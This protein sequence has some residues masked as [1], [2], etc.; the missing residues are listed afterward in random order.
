MAQT[1][2]ELEPPDLAGWLWVAVGLLAAV[3]LVR[4]VARGRWPRNRGLRAAVAIGVAG[5]DACIIFGRRD[6]THFYYVHLSN[7]SNA[8]HNAIIR[9]DGETRTSLIPPG[10]QEPIAHML[11]K[12]WHKVDL[13]R[14][15]DSGLITVYVDAYD[16]D[17]K[18]CMQ[19]TDKTYDWGHVGLGSFNDHASFAHLLIEGQTR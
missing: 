12:A 18:P 5:R 19:V 4:Y 10:S 14:D 8:H 7:I 11:D 16:A 1:R 9:V 15:V 3:E 17:A 13:L 2:L 6:D